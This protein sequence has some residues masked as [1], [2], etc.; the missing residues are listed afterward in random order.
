MFRF[1]LNCSLW[2]SGLGVFLLGYAVLVEPA[3]LKIRELEFVS[4]K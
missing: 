3:Q 2:V 1:L 4:D